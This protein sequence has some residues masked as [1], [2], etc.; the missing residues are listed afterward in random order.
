MG[1][2]VFLSHLLSEGKRRGCAPEQ[3]LAQAKAMGVDRVTESDEKLP[4]YL[5][6]LQEAGF[7]PNIVYCVSRLVHGEDLE[8]NLR[9]AELTAKAGGTILMM[10]PGFYQNGLTD[11]EALRNGAPLLK[12]VVRACQSLGIHAAI[13]DY[14]GEFTPYSTVK[15]VVRMLDAAEGLEFVYDSGNILYHREDPLALWDATAD[16]IVGIHAKD[17]APAPLPNT[18]AYP[19]P[20]GDWICPTAFGA[21]MLPA[22]EICHRIGQKGIRP[23]DITLEH[24]GNGAPD[25]LDF[26]RRSLA[27][28]EE[29]GLK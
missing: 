29:T 24:D 23:E 14:G 4:Q 1:Y 19:T 17:L 10:V 27:F 5:P 11:E 8:K 7:R 15:Q 22:A 12:E 3:I 16:R 2:G 6:L 20:A 9:A 18:K 25:T 21:G 28:F 26:L 13:E